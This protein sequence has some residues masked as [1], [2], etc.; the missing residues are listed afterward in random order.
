MKTA[1]SGKRK[2]EDICFG[3]GP[4]NLQGMH[5]IFTPI[6]DQALQTRFLAEEKYQGIPNLLHGGIISLVFDE[7]MAAYC[8]FFNRRSLTASLSVKFLRP[9]KVGQTITFEARMADP[10]KSRGDFLELKGSAT[11]EAGRAVA[12]AKALMKLVEQHDF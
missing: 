11:D 8:A 1:M 10:D 12:K 5:L 6:E 4:K 9:V 7:L 3:C 2:H